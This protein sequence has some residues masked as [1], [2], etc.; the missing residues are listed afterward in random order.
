MQ[1][2]SVLLPIQVGILQVLGLKVT[3]DHRAYAELLAKCRLFAQR[4]VQFCGGKIDNVYMQN[5]E[6]SGK[7]IN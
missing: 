6:F 3:N 5:Q 4:I 7:T 2:V 1:T